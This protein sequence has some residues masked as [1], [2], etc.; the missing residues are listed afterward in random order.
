LGFLGF[1]IS[2]LTKYYGGNLQEIIEVEWKIP[3]H[4]S[5][6]EDIE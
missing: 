6:K 3:A 2:D 4:S 5:K 1:H